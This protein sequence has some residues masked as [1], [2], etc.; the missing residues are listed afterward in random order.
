MIKTK[1]LF[2]VTVL[3]V[4]SCVTGPNRYPGPE[5]KK[6]QKLLE[7]R[8]LQNSIKVIKKVPQAL[9]DVPGAR[10]HYPGLTDREAKR[11]LNIPVYNWSK[12]I[13]TDASYVRVKHDYFLEFNKW[14]IGATK[15]FYRKDLGDG[16]DCDNF[17]H[18]Y[19]SL[20]ATAAY[21]NSSKR[22]VLA[23]VIFVAQREAFGGIKGGEYN[24]A[25]NLIGT[26][27]GWFVIEPQTGKMCE[28][29]DYPNNIMWYIF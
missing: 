5:E 8:R 22:E 18:L 19:K 26:E 25:L 7:S 2:I 17:A 23:G 14:F 24:H 9:E 6:E 3:L 20:L 12:A 28:L 10:Y 16:Y 13:F 1:L 21:K 27:K 11:S 29:K 15:R 4:S